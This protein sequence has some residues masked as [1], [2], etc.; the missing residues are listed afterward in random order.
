MDEALET[1]RANCYRR[2]LGHLSD[3][4]WMWVCEQA[5]KQ[6]WF[7]SINDL[8]DLAERAPIN[9]AR[10]Q[11]KLLARVEQGKPADFR[12]FP[13]EVYQG[14]VN[15]YPRHPDEGALAYVVRIAELVGVPK[16]EGERGAWPVGE[17][18][19]K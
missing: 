2:D 5:R 18:A 9:E 17:K 7:P 14:F 19:A 15:E 10:A 11:W 3:E 16:G 6:E 13:F 1:E 12:A 8:L 4:Q